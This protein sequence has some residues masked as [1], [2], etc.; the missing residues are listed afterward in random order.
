M[1]ETVIENPVVNS[2]LADP[3]PHFKLDDDGILPH[4]VATSESL[5]AIQSPKS[6]RSD[7]Y[8]VLEQRLRN[9]RILAATVTGQFQ[10]LVPATVPTEP[11]APRPERSAILGF[12]GGLL[13]GFVL[14]IIFSSSTKR[15][16]GRREVTDALGLPIVGV[17][18]EVPDK[19]LKRGAL[20]SLTDPGAAASEA[21]RLLRSNLDN[22]NVDDVSS[23]LVTSSVANEGKTTLACNLAVTLATA[24][25]RVVVV[26]RDLRKP[27]VHE[28]FGIANDVGLSSEV[29][30]TAKPADALR[31]IDLPVPGQRRRVHG[32]SPPDQGA[33]SSERRRLVVLPSGP[34][35]S[36][37][38][39][40]VASKRFAGIMAGLHKTN[41][42][43]IIVDSPT[44]SCC[45]GSRAATYVSTLI[46]RMRSTIARP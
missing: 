13:A 2:A 7:D 43:F 20:I 31:P 3:G 40:V 42:D 14:A 36:D 32:G 18:P 29:A 23:L 8:M 11:F 10:L 44:M 22:V 37:P 38:G 21:L 33:A 35:P 17:I 1:R 6:R 46:P 12:G 26:D 5:K 24:G 45:G 30:G 41:V 34:R 4:R 16:R 28:Y 19:S 25:N 9:L 39:E 15:V 27:R